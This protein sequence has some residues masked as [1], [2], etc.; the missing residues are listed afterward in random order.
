MENAD[1][2]NDSVTLN[3]LQNMFKY[4]DYIV[5]NRNFIEIVKSN[6]E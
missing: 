2:H 1:I 4:E 3:D 5:R 6:I